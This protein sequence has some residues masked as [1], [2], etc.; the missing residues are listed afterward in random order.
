M[1]FPL[2][3]FIY[4]ILDPII[5]FIMYNEVDLFLSIL[6]TCIKHQIWHITFSVVLEAKEQPTEHDEIS[7]IFHSN[8]VLTFNKIYVVCFFFL[9]HRKIRTGK[10]PTK[11]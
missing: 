1:F 5:H 11:L 7:F 6:Y 2:F 9:S 8:I 3:Q 10:A 4:N